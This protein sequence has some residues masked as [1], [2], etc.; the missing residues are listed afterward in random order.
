VAIP[1]ILTAEDFGERTQRYALP[2][3]RISPFFSS[4]ASAIGP[5]DPGARV[6]ATTITELAKRSRERVNNSEEF[7]D[8]RRKIDE[9]RE[10]DGV[11]RLADMMA[12]REEADIASETDGM[13]TDASPGGGSPDAPTADAG[14]P[15]D[16]ERDEEIAALTPQV[17]E[18]LKILTDLVALSRRGT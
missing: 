8:V 5:R 7:A 10:N 6:G 9:A 14:K 17:E 12:S 3:E 13:P 1:S 2:S 16:A 4:Y 18:A 11:V 15:A